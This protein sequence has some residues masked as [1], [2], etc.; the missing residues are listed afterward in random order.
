MPSSAYTQLKD[1]IENTM[2]MSHIYQPAMLKTLLENQ[3]EADK[4]TIGRVFLSYDSSQVEYYKEIV[5]NMPGRILK[6]HGL[7]AVGPRGSGLFH[8]KQFDDLSTDEISALTMLCEVALSDYIEKRGEGIW[9]HRNHARDA[10][11][12]SIRYQVLKRAEHRCELCGI[13]AEEK[14][15]EVDHIIPKSLGGLDALEN[16]QALCYT[17]NAQKKNHDKTD[18]RDWREQYLHREPECIFCT[19]K[20]IEIVGENELAYALTDNFPVSEHHTLIIPKRHVDTYFEMNQAEVNACHALLHEQKARIDALDSTVTGFNIGNN[21][22]EVA[23]QSVFHAHIHVIPRRK[24]DQKNPR[25]GVR[26]IF[27]EKADY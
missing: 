14:A 10:V 18:F 12:G 23:G 4:E 7:V 17:C 16:Y 27:P 8:L 25:G 5:G 22:G 2:S 21:A 11:P 24:D 19:L 9:A 20:N 26:R 15:L 6:N 3:G 13:S 1:F